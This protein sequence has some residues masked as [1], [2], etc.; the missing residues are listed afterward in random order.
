M[1]RVIS[2]LFAVLALTGAAHATSYKINKIKGQTITVEREARFFDSG[3]SKYCYRCDESYVTTFCAPDG[4]QLK[5]KF[6]QFAVNAPGDKLS[7]YD[8]ADTSGSLIGHFQGGNSPCGKRIVSTTGCLTVK[9]VSNSTGVNRGWCAKINAIV[10][11]YEIDE[12]DG[13][14]VTDC[15][16]IFTDSGGKCGKYRCDEN[17]NVTFTSPEAGKQVTL[18]FKHFCVNAPGDKLYLYDGTDADAPLIGKFQ[19]YK[20]PSIVRSTSG[21]IYAVFVSNN[22]GVN[23]GWKAEISCEEP[24]YEIDQI[25]GKTVKVCDGKFTDSG[26]VKWNYRNNECYHATLCAPEGENLTLDFTTFCVQEKYD[27][28][29]IFDGA[30]EDAPLIGKFAG[31]NSPGVVTSSGRSLH[32]AFYSNCRTTDCGWVA[33]ISCKP[34]AELGNLVWFDENDNGLKDDNENGIDGVRVELYLCDQTP[35]QDQPIASQD[36][37][38]GGQYLFDGLDAGEYIVCIPVPPASAPTSSTSV[39]TED[40]QV[41]NNNNGDQSPDTGKVLSPCIELFDGESDL[42]ID[43]GF[44]IPNAKI[45][46]LVWRDVNNNGLKD[47]TE[48]GIGGVLL[49]LYLCGQIPGQDDPVA[50]QETTPEGNYLFENLFSGEYFVHIPVPPAGNRSSSTGAD[51]EDNQVDNNDNGDQPITRGGP[52]SSGCVNLSA[53]ECDLTIDFGFLSRK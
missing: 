26:G 7:I 25:N 50:T 32:F 35:G 6:W 20:V 53:G 34:K 36:T 28:L 23:S 4:C 24:C 13:K 31:S 47:D 5:M 2:S 43:F 41:D 27:K 9:F 14:V 15:K 11:E 52:T 17:Y 48:Q 38:N 22:T 45:G 39:D 40:N 8:G 21:S 42:T 10:P 51:L 29:Y 16:G 19:G 37:S 49:E 1:L 18:D 30:D 33:K 44:I 46:N 12:Y 3:G